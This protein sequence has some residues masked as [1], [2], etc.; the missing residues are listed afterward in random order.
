MNIN[1]IKHETWITNPTEMN[2]RIQDFWSPYWTRDTHQD[3]HDDEQWQDSLN[4]IDST[5]KQQ[6]EIAIPVCSLDAWRVAIRKT[7]T[8]T[9]KGSCGF[10]KSEL[11]SLSDRALQD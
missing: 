2:K 6:P 3:Q 4:I 11:D 5:I 9:A 1:T 7:K 8:R 10:S